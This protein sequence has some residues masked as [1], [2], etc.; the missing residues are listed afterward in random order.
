MHWVAVLQMQKDIN[1]E[2]K[3]KPNGISLK[4]LENTL[5][6][7]H[8]VMAFSPMDKGYAAQSQQAAVAATKTK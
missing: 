1:P 5:Y 3:T 4:L 8:E 2:N 7:G 6:D